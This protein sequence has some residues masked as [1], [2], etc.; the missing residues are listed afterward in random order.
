MFQGSLDNLGDWNKDT[1]SKFLDRLKTLGSVYTYQDK[2]NNIWHYD[3]TKKN[4]ADYD[5]D[6][7][8]D[9]SYIRVNSHI[10]MVYNDISK[11][12]K[13]ILPD[14]DIR[15][16]CIRFISTRLSGNVLDQRFSIWTG[17]GANGK[18]VL[19]ELIRNTFGDY[20][21]NLPVTLLTQ[22]RK[23]SNSAS[24]EKAR[25]R[26]VRICYL[27]EPDSNEKINAGEMKELSGGDMIQ[28][29]KLYG[30]VFEFKPQ[31]EMILMC[32][33]LPT[34]DDKSAGSWR[35]VQVY[36]FV[37]RFVDEEKQVNIKR[38]IY[39]KDKELSIKT[40][41]W[42]IVFLSMLLIEW[43]EMKGGI[44]EDSI[45]DSI[46]LETESYKN[47]NDM[48]GTWITEDLI[49]T[50]DETTPF[51]ILYNSFTNWYTENYTNGKVDQI[52]VKKRL[53]EWQ[54]TNYGFTDEINGNLRYPKFNLKP[55]EEE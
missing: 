17:V 8:F 9:L 55:I 11:F 12:F 13:E 19:I 21:V 48:I 53:I 42:C 6:L 39:K 3:L 4:H 33:E 26:G 23:A 20:C 7:D 28:A 52:N 25:T 15:K 18:S 37:S 10:K 47:R 22:K 54:N 41:K 16:Y 45:P 5:D 38:H 49:E 43:S 40:N 1:K 24:P 30:D 35:R 31:F 32:N 50:R 51:N 36:P 14:K 27:Q 2:I 34:I 44:D 29:R 46:R